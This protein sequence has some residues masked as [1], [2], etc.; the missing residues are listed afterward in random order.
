VRYQLPDGQI[1]ILGRPFGYAGVNYPDNW[2]QSMS[3]EERAAFGAVEVP[4]PPP[5]VA[6]A[7]SPLDL[8]HALEATITL[9]RL[10]EA[11]LTVEGRVWLENIEDQIAV[12]RGQL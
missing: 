9:R 2:L 1:V 11:V 10:R 3:A 12:H 8:I 4:E 5:P 6:P 7:P